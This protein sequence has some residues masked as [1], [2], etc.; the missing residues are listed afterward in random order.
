M[1]HAQYVVAKFKLEKQ[2]EEETTTYVKIIQRAVII[3]LGISLKK[4]R[5][6]LQKK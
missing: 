1:N 3:Y 5:F 4:E 6:G 2:K